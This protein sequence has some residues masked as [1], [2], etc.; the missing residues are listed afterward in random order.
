[1]PTERS[2]GFTP[3]N[4]KQGEIVFRVSRL[5]PA[6]ELFVIIMPRRGLDGTAAYL[7]RVVLLC[8]SMYFDKL[9]GPAKSPSPSWLGLSPC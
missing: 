1:M 5:A 7:E 6:D 9:D 4:R 8:A 3:C 2:Q